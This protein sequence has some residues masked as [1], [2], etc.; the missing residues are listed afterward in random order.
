LRRWSHFY[1]HGE[2]DL[3]D[4]KMIDSIGLS[5]SKKHIYHSINVFADISHF[6]GGGAYLR[7]D[8]VPE[9]EEYMMILLGFGLF[10]WQFKR[11]Q[12]KAAPVAA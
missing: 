1:L 11:K 5:V 9:P 12:R 6:G 8:D 3:S 7:V 2:Y 4:E 10:G